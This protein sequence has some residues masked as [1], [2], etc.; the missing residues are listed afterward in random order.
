MLA[1]KVQATPYDL[2]R[3]VLNEGWERVSDVSASSRPG[4][5]YPFIV[6]I[7]SQAENVERQLHRACR[8]A[9]RMGG[10]D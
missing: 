3:T 7:D 10:E 2:P 5:Y 8:V 9:F 4:S 1:N 6:K